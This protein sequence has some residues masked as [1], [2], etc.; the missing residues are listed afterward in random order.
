M[1]G[2]RKIV[3]DHEEH[4]DPDRFADVLPLK[5][6]IGEPFTTYC[7]DYQWNQAFCSELKCREHDDGT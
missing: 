5:A 7:E 1:Q 3:D 2:E 6:V 4:S